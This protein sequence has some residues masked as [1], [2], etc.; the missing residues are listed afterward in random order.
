VTAAEQ[1]LAVAQLQLG[2]PYVYGDEGPD[3]FDCSGLMQYVYG[4][5]GIALPRTA[6]EQQAWATPVSRPLPG[7]LVFY[8]RP[9]THV[10]LYLGNGKMISAP[11]PG[12]V[13]HVGGIGTPTSYGRVPGAGA[14]L[15]PAVTAVSTATGWLGDQLGSLLGGAR[16]VV[17]E[18]T[19]VL[20]GL[21][22]LAAGTYWV[23]A[24]GTRRLI[25]GSR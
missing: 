6:H 18:G 11:H 5:A 10:G 8:G 7:D 23:A 13:V 14:L 20:L 21:A 25:T 1:A 4:Q 3:S 19:F 2:E 17:L 9:A 15:T 16:H 24:G 12:A 22:L